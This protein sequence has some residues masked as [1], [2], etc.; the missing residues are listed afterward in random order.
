MIH[1]TRIWAKFVSISGR[2]PE[3][4]FQIARQTHLCSRKIESLIN[5]IR[6]TLYATK[7]SRLQSGPN[8]ISGASHFFFSFRICTSA[9]RARRSNR[10]SNV[11]TTEQF[12]GVEKF[13][14]SV[15]VVRVRRPRRENEQKKRRKTKNQTRKWSSKYSKNTHENLHV[16]IWLRGIL[17]HSASDSCRACTLWSRRRRFSRSSSSS[18]LSSLREKKCHFSRMI[19]M[20]GVQ[21]WPPRR[22]WRSN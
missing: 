13:R 9:V 12:S 21:R 19:K 20:N 7:S 11:N 16:S 14:W 3:W 6:K 10:V 5:N 2:M 1:C 18:L 4:F 22:Q 8:V 17:F 15:A